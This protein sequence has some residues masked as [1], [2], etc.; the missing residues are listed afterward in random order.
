M[1]HPGVAEEGNMYNL[2]HKSEIDRL[3]FGTKNSFVEFVF[4]DSPEGSNEAT[5]LLKTDRIIL[6]TWK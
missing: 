6:M 5:T 1:L 2:E 3:F 4:E